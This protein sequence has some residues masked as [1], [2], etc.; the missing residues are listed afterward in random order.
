MAIKSSIL[1]TVGNTPI[2]RINKLGPATVELYA[3]L[4]AF[5]PLGSVKDRLALGMIEAAEKDGSLRPGQTV[6]EATSGNTGIGLAMVCAQKGYSLVITMAESFSV[7]R[8]KLM[9]FLGAKVILTP[10]S[11]K[12]TG[13]VGKAKELAEKHGWFLARQFEN[14]ANAD[15]HSR[16]TARE[17][18]ADFEGLGLDYWV[19][20]F[21]T[22]GTL[23]GVSRVLRAES[24]GTRIVV[25][26]PENSQLLS[27]GIP[28][29]RN[30]DGSASGSHPS[31]ER[32]MMQGW[33]PDFIPKL[34]GDAQAAGVIDLLQPV[35]G[36]DALQCVHDLARQEGIFCGISGGATMAAALSVARSAPDGSRILAMIPDTGERY[37]STPLFEN[38]AETMT[39]EE[40]N[41]AASTPR[42]RFDVAGGAG[43]ASGPH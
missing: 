4:E 34:A 20:G 23:K 30:Q 38:V 36:A 29:E 33:T 16:T 26:E 22:G 31:F 43:A 6:I 32:H 3:K 2:V 11:E 28:Q 5:N 35:A 8:R 42:F 15:M 19:T 12:G 7:E 14:E 40:M 21:G 17:I 25:A 13:M 24:P 1:E 39:E 10:A 37:L 9:R 18:L 27:S 41:I